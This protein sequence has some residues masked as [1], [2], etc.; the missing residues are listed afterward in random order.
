[1]PLTQFICPDGETIAAAECVKK[2]RMTTR[3]LTL[4]TIYKLLGGRREW[5]GKPSTT[6]LINGT[7]MEYLKI[8]REY[9]IAPKK[10]AYALL[11][12]EHHE[13]LAKVKV[14]GTIAE[15]AIEGEDVDVTGVPDLLEPVEDEDNTY[16]LIDYKTWGSYSVV[17]LLGIEKYFV[18]HPTEKYQRNT[19]KFKVGDPKQVPA[20]KTNPE[21]ID[22]IEVALQLNHY[23]ILLE[24]RGYNIRNM[25]L[26]ITVRDGGTQVATSRGI[27]EKIYYPVP[28][29][30]LDDNEVLAYFKAKR[31]NLKRALQLQVAPEPCNDT[32]AWDGR[33]CRDYCEVA[34]MCPR[35]IR[36]KRE[37]A[38]GSSTLQVPGVH[39]P[40]P[41]A[42]QP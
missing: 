28:V 4:P 35:G 11:G 27:T 39:A 38:T 12:T 25:L 34:K 8:T 3:C 16:N 2:C 37:T 20:F 30:H 10:S 33:R 31:I 41:L 15:D 1:M 18:P 40:L 22:D 24:K 6:Q 26:Q 21:K 13:L 9:A 32:E 17:R 23:R 29:R 36:E 7:M 14:P 5:S 42:V 19:G